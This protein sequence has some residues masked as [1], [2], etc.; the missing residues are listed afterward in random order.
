MAETMTKAD[1]H[2]I[3]ESILGKRVRVSE[4]A[5]DEARED[6]LVLADIF[7]SVE[8]GAI[9][10]TYPDDFPYPSCLIS[11]ESK[12]GTPIH[13]V[14]AY[15]HETKKTILITVYKPDPDRWIDW[16]IRKEKTNDALE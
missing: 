11:G 2:D 9:I 7:H 10:E 12:A 3:I 8:N 4:H 15:N 5:K 14:W 6:E 1:I 13:S 16:R